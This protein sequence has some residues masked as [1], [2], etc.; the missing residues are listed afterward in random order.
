MNTQERI[1]RLKRIKALMS[2]PRYSPKTSRRMFEGM[3]Y[4]L[5]ISFGFY[6]QEGGS[7]FLTFWNILFIFTTALS[8]TCGICSV[9][10]DSQQNKQLLEQQIYEYRPVDTKSYAALCEQIKLEG[11]PDYDAVGV[12]HRVESLNALNPITRSV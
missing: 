10:P 4:L 5:V 9:F 11:E 1:K 6:Y 3:F 12:W 7:E 2:Y 8:L